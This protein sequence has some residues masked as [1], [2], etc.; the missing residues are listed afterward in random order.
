MTT[1][2][3]YIIVNFVVVTFILLYHKIRFIVNA[4]FDV[5]SFHAPNFII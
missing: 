4:V 2:A 1:Y 3:Y 5:L